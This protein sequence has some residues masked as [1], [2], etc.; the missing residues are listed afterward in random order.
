MTVRDAALEL[1]IEQLIG[2][3]NKKLFVECAGVQ[4]MMLPTSPSLVAKLASEVWSREP[5]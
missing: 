1:S 5:K 3:L 4:S 2:A